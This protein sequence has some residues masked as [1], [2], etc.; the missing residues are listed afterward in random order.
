MHRPQEN[1][2][3]FSTGRPA[4]QV[5]VAKIVSAC[6]LLSVTTCFWYWHVAFIKSITASGPIRQGKS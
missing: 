5:H 6:L 4:H 2:S 3:E 1:F